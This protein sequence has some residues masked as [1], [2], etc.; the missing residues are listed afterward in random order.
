M[1]QAVVANTTY[2]ISAGANKE[3]EFAAKGTKIVF[4]GFMKA[5]TEGSDDPE[6][7]LDNTEKFL[8]NIKQGTI[9]NLDKLTKEQNFTKPPARYTEASLVKKLEAEGIGRPSTYAPTI[10]TIQ[11]REYIIKTDDKKLK[12]TLIGTVVNDFLVEHFSD[13]M[14]YTFTASVETEFDEIA[15]GKKVWN[16]MIA[17]FYGG[18]KEKV[19]DVIGNVG[20]ASGERELGVDPTSGNKIF[21]RIGP[22]GPMV[23]L[24]EKQEDEEA[25][26]PKFASLLKGQTIQTIT[27]DD[28]LDL[29]KLPRTVGEWEGKEVVASVGRFGPYLP[30]DGKFTSIKKTDEEDPL[31]IDLERSIELIKIKIQADKDR[32]ISNFEGDPLIQVLNGRYGP[33]I[34]VSPP[35]AK[36]INVK[37]PKG[38]EPKGLTREDCVNLWEN[39]PAKKPRGKKK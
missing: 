37:I 20:K 16:E 5:Y 33:F 12:P 4:A 34:Q 9:L 35:K 8:P 19:V 32:L 25:P 22:F 1:A 38:T 17:S 2:K 11:A 10:A 28:A 15:E 3:Y 39:Q 24:G 31:T 36:K 26:K 23:Q 30:Y 21:A 14:E 7:A 29:F 13:V 27:L 6:A 18:F